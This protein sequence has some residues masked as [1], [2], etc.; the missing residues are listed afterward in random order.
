[1][2]YM[3]VDVSTCL[4]GPEF[5]LGVQGMMWSL[6]LA[7]ACGGGQIKG[8]ILVQRCR[9]MHMVGT[10]APLALVQLPVCS[11]CAF[12]GI[13]WTFAAELKGSRFHLQR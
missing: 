10:S 12:T 9:D 11:I 6:K 7:S 8:Q 1:M 13:D 4:Q 3:R 2:Q 5:L